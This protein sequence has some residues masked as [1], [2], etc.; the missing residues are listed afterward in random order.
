M[1]TAPQ[2]TIRKEAALIMARC[3]KE[4]IRAIDRELKK[5]KDTAVGE[6][7]MAVLHTKR[8]ALRSAYD[9]LKAAGL[10]MEDTTIQNW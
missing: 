2:I 5:T 6:M 1:K 4:S 9:E 7:T 3:L 8:K 10:E